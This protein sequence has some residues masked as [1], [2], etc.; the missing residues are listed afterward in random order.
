MRF[1]KA[2]V[3]V[4]GVLIVIGTVVLV[5][6]IVNQS[7]RIGGVDPERRTSD[8]GNLL[9]LPLGLPAGATLEQATPGA[10]GVVLRVNV[11]GEGTVVYLVPWDGR[12]RVVRITLGAG[13]K[14]PSGA[15]AKP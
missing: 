14:A 13:A 9:D 11:P 4:M 15:P 1:L 8:I 7:G 12:G 2:S 6:G 10:R 3:I 5:V